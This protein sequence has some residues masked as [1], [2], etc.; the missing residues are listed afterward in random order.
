ML[1][2]M[3]MDSNFA[4]ITNAYIAEKI[5]LYLRKYRKIY[6][7]IK[8]MIFPFFGVLAEIIRFYSHL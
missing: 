5:I 4:R 6:H 1:M 8:P 2:G 7:F 3:H